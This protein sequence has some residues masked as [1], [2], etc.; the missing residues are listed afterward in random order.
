MVHFTD[1][2]RLMQRGSAVYLWSFGLWMEVKEYK[3]Q[4][5]ALVVPGVTYQKLV[6]KL[7]AE[8]R[9]LQVGIMESFIFQSKFY[10]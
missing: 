9:C 2:R 5:K 3:S 4:S 1:K 8:I 7:K 6:R 10:D